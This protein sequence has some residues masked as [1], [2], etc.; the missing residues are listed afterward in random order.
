MTNSP[1]IDPEILEERYPVRLERFAI[2]QGSGGR[3]RWRGADGMQ[4]WLR[5]LEPMTD[6]LLLGSQRYRI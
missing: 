2:R 1:L 5:F 3:G 6:C 4:R